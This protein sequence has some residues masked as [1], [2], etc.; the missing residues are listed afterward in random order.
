[1]M[2]GVPMRR[3]AGRVGAQPRDG[4]EGDV[5][6]GVG[7]FRLIFRPGEWVGRHL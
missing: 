4:G 2:K 6:G 1:M 3:P 5:V 7:G